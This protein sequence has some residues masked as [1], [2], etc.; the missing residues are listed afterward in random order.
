MNRELAELL[1]RHRALCD[2]N[3]R[4]K[5][6]LALLTQQKLALWKD[7]KAA[8]RG[9]RIWEAVADKYLDQVEA[10]VAE[11]TTANARIDQLTEGLAF[12]KSQRDDNENAWQ[13]EKQKRE[14]W[15]KLA[16]ERAA[17]LIVAQAELERRTAWFDEQT[18][19]DSARIAQLEAYTNRCEDLDPPDVLAHW[20]AD[21]ARITQAVAELERALGAEWRH[22]TTYDAVV[23]GIAALK[24]ET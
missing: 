20:Q 4:L 22:T 9:A 10:A 13:A 15:H 21:R 19:K 18:A 2:E 17:A 6:A 14:D 24:G 16:D 1:E 7:A 11:L 8:R 12:V 5:Q 3:K 23:R